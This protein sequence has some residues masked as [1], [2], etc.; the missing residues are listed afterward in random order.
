MKTI[1]IWGKTSDC[2]GMNTDDGKSYDGYPPSFLGDGDS[3]ELKIDI[4]TGKIVGWNAEEVVKEL[5][6]LE[7]EGELK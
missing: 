1:T 4:K 7:D 3:V 5:K 2:F 6:D